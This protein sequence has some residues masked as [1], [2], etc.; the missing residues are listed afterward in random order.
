MSQLSHEHL[1]L[2]ISE[3]DHLC[4]CD[5]ALFHVL[6]LSYGLVQTSWWAHPN[7]NLILNCAGS[8]MRSLRTKVARWKEHFLIGISKRP[9]CITRRNGWHITQGTEPER[10]M[11]RLESCCY[12]MSRS[13]PKITA[14]LKLDEH[15]SFLVCFKPPLDFSSYCLHIIHSQLSVLLGLRLPM[16]HIVVGSQVPPYHHCALIVLL[17]HQILPITHHGFCS[18][19]NHVT[20][21][22]HTTL[23]THPVQPI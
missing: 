20:L 6:K 19:P 17:Y 10:T 12:N 16:S 1:S 14:S 15:K 23:C 3:H 13:G 2:S 22:S 8:P 21:I 18:L 5:H 7:G 4:G 11:L 9:L